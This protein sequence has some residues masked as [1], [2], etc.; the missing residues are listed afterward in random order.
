MVLTFLNKYRDVGLLILRVG[1]GVMMFIHGF[2]KA[3]IDVSAWER[4]GNA[5][6]APLAPAVFGG[7]AILFE[8]L[9]GLLLAAGFLT[10]I[11]LL[12]LI[13]V[14]LGALSFH[15][16]APPDKGGGF[17]NASHALELLIV[18]LGLLFIG[19]GAYSVDRK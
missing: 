18:F 2:G 11:A 13:C 16:Q 8:M 14:M 1:L 3:S 10:R 5:A 12:M 7:L 6:H 4:L 9:G 15:F 19:P 17:N